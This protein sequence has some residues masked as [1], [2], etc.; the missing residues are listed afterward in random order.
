MRVLIKYFVVAVVLV[1]SSVTLPVADDG[2]IIFPSDNELDL[3]EILMTPE[4]R[5]SVN[6]DDENVNIGLESGSFF[7]GDIK[8]LADQKEI[9][10]SNETD[11]GLL[12]RTGILI[13]SQRWPKNKLGNVVVPFAFKRESD[14]SE[15]TSVFCS[16]HKMFCFS[17]HC[18]KK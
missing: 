11:E 4:E 1:K 7:Q 17:S 9:L 3:S 13:E 5:M 16:L 2:Q 6:L 14:Y 8:L 12:S 10:L 15:L 18:S